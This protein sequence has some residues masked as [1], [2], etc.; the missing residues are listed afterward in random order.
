MAQDLTPM[1]TALIIRPRAGALTP[2]LPPALRSVLEEGT[3]ARILPAE[4]GG[5]IELAEQPDWQPPAIEDQLQD[6]A[7]AAQEALVAHLEAVDEGMLSLIVAKLLAHRWRGRS[8]GIAPQVQEAL[9][10]DWTED[11]EEFPRWAID[12][13]CRD[14]RRRE[15]WH[16]TISDIRELCEAAVAEDR[17][18]LRLLER[19]LAAQRRQ[20]A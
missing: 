20:A 3:Y 2:S 15:A 11:L 14:Y 8:E 6:V 18:S 4:R 16:P 19:L 17:R 10:T 7:V 12:K 5:G 9:L 13:A 1:P